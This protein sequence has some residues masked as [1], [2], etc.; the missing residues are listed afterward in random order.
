MPQTSIL[1]IG[2]T[3]IIS[4]AF[5]LPL[6]SIVVA[7]I[8]AGG[9]LLVASRRR[10]HDRGPAQPPEAA[11][12]SIRMRYLPE[13][14]TL[15]I[16]AIGV[17]VLFAVENVMRGYVVNLPGLVSWWRFATP[18]FCALLAICVVFGLIVAR[19]SAPTEVPVVPAVRRTWT[20]FSS[21][22]SVICASLVLLALLATT[23]GA[24]L[25]SSANGEG[26]YVWL[27]IPVPNEADIDPIRLGFYGWAYGIP[28]LI[29]LAALA[30]MSW[31]VPTGP[32]IP[33]KG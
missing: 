4:A 25:A 6:F 29:C 1:S 30:S 3:E 12:R 20:S 23:V 21:R 26:Q 22:S 32:L 10:H 14:R 13:H 5:S 8:A 19:G 7:V 31:A 15:G 28:V 27:E 11:A 2:P 18:V 17:C 33:R 16:A 24:G 9:I